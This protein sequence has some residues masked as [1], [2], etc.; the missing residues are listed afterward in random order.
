VDN[1]NILITDG[2]S[3]NGIFA[4]SVGGGGGDS[5]E[6]IGAITIG[7]SGGVSGH[8]GDVNV[9]NEAGANITTHGDLANGI[10]AISIGGG[11]GK[12]AADYTGSPLGFTLDIGG[13]NGNGYGG[14]IDVDNAGTITTYGLNS[15]GILAQSVGGGGG[16]GNYTGDFDVTTTLANLTVTIG[17]SNGSGGY[18]GDVTVNN[19]ASGVITAYGAN[20]TAIFAQSVGGGGGQSNTTLT[21]STGAVSSATV[22]VGGSAASGN[23]GDVS[24]TNA[25]QITIEGNNS[26]AILAQ[27]VGG[28]GGTA[29]SA[30]GTSTVP[31]SIA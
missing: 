25:G 23:G 28:G 29:G 30:L 26:I 4:E 19:S 20:S 15:T 16:D 2:T 11:G 10:T 21:A 24:V 7:G 12:G 31:V 6:T 22:S 14:D 13:S 18:G 27:S 8:G 3:S 17:G 5:G 9:T 1:S